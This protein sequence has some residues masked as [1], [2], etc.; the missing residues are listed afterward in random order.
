MAISNNF[1]LLYCHFVL[2]VYK[3][4]SL[5][6][7]VPDFEPERASETK[8]SSSFNRK[9][10]SYVGSLRPLNKR[11]LEESYKISSSSLQ[12]RKRGDRYNPSQVYDPFNPWRNSGNQRTTTTT[13]I[14]T[15]RRTKPTLAPLSSTTT[16]FFSFFDI[17]ENPITPMR[18][19]QKDKWKTST[20]STTR[21]PRRPPITLASTVSYSN[22]EYY[23]QQNSQNEPSRSESIPNTRMIDY[24]NSA[25]SLIHNTEIKP[26]K[27]ADY[28]SGNQEDPINPKHSDNFV[29]S[30]PQNRPLVVENIMTNED[31]KLD[32]FWNFINSKYK[33]TA[34]SSLPSSSS[35]ASPERSTTFVP[36]DFPNRE[37][38]RR[39]QQRPEQ[40]QH[41][42]KPTGSLTQRLIQFT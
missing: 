7:L 22:T 24:F 36:R 23:M 15:T 16:T 35:R 5:F 40:T 26:H 10:P 12:R 4:V 19:L 27:E 1:F 41:D 8:K 25:A 20:S 31:T 11:S 21:R 37:D 38:G 14:V 3:F 28:Y 17:V 32:V 18:S 39:Q 6:V 33:T 13:T 30:R 29:K 9:Q 42:D 2:Y 34:K